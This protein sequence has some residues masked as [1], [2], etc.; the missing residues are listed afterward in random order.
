M[1]ARSHL[2]QL[3]VKSEGFDEK[4]NV[5]VQEKERLEEEEKEFKAFH[6]STIK[7]LS[8]FVACCMRQTVKVQNHISAT[9]GKN[10]VKLSQNHPK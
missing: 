8:R 7:T 4:L 3:L 6:T 2:S 1:A 9:L 5:S 10:N